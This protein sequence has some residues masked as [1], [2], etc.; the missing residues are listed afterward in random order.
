[1]PEI[2]IS[3]LELVIQLVIKTLSKSSFKIVLK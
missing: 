1:M 2:T 3:E